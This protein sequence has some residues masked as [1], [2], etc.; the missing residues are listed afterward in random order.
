MKALS[1]L[2][3][4][5]LPTGSQWS[6]SQLFACLSQ[7]L[8]LDFSR[9]SFVSQGYEQKQMESHTRICIRMQDNYETLDTITGSEPLLA[10]AA[11]HV[12]QSQSF[13]PAEA[14]KLL[15]DSFSVHKG[16]RGELL[17]ILL[18]TLARDGAVGPSTNQGHPVSGKRIF[19]VSQ[20]LA[21]LLQK[22]K[23]ENIRHHSDPHAD[24]NVVEEFYNEFKHCYMHFNHFVKIHQYGVLRPDKLLGL[25]S[26]G[27]GILCANSQ[28]GVDILLLGYEG[29]WASQ[30]NQVL[31]M[32]QSKN[33]SHYTATPNQHTLDGMDPYKLG[34][35]DIDDQAVE[36]QKPV[37]R[38][39]FALAVKKENAKVTV[40]RRTNE[41]TLK[42]K[43][44]PAHQIRYTSYDIWI[45]GLSSDIL[46][47]ILPQ[48][49]QVWE[50][51]LQASYGWEEPFR[52]I[53]EQAANLRRSMDA[54][55]A[56]HPAHWSQ[57]IK[58]PEEEAKSQAQD[59]FGPILPNPQGL[60]PS[61]TMP[62]YGAGDGPAMRTS[63]SQSSSKGGSKSKANPEESSKG[64]SEGSSKKWAMG[65]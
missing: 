53:S 62:T 14:L 3:R 11:Y 23:W 22:F 28:A 40:Q 46:G 35:W 64:G 56:V 30:V 32:I 63:G 51:L 33:D 5:G 42:T 45:A 54:G 25:S 27:S 16:D 12:M 41:Y 48:E 36:H 13:R 57:W 9:T 39:V 18:L 24:V 47:P 15:L 29:E 37:I 6:K 20:F 59:A 10:E 61:K 60:I 44:S 43:G 2:M 17:S 52:G 26:R 65:M 58:T 7:R 38:I 4:T 21:Q 19:T 8:A 31:I 1:V 34:I 55:S 50:A 49:N